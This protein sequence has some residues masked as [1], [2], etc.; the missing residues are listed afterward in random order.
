MVLQMIESWYFEDKIYY[1][2]IF[3]FVNPALLI[4][5]VFIM[6]WAEWFKQATFRDNIRSSSSD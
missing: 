4:M 3:V 2:K 5:I 1:W 6:S